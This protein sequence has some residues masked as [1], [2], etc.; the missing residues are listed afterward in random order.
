[1]KKVEITKTDLE[2]F[3]DNSCTKNQKINTKYPI[4]EV[5]ILEYTYLCTDGNY[6]KVYYK[7][8]SN[9]YESLFIRFS[10][11]DIEEIFKKY[12]GL[13]I[14]NLYEEVEMLYL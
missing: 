11:K 10:N 6:Y 9:D 14:Y 3:I 5:E 12:F 7:N 1:M 8:D 4:I 13:N 2:Y